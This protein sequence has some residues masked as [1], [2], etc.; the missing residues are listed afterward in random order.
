MTTGETMDHAQL[1]MAQWA[2]ERPETDTSGMLTVA[3]LTRLSV[4]IGKE[5]GQVHS[6][7]SLGSW[8]FDVL[9]TLRRQPPPHRSTIKGLL[10]MVMVSSAAMTHRIDR[11]VARGLVRRF[12]NPE[13]RRETFIELTSEG[14]D[15]V[16]GVIDAHTDKCNEVV[17]GLTPREHEQLDR[18]LLKVLASNGDIVGP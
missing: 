8:E 2:R 7:V 4:L 12:E 13:S 1:F 3:R 14:L 10:G 15:S 5:I 9:A 11:L 16:E 17:A 18:L 6:D